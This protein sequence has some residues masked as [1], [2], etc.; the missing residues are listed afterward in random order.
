MGIATPVLFVIVT[1]HG[2]S[3]AQFA[4]GVP[5]GSFPNASVVA[6]NTIVGCSV[7]FATN[8]AL[9]AVAS[10]FVIVV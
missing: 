4:K 1:T 10:N 8:A 6:E 5:T 2:T 3:G 7:S 9:T